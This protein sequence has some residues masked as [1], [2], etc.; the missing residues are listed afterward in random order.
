M[1]YLITC[2][3]IVISS[4]VFSQNSILDSPEVKNSTIEFNGGKYNGYLIEFNASPDIVEEAIKER[5]KLQGIKPKET[6]SFMV[7]RNVVIPL[8]DPVKPMDAF[9]KVERKSRKEKEQTIVYFISAN[10]G[11]IPED[12]LKS[13]AASKSVGVTGIKKGDAF[14]T[15]LIPDV[16]QGVYNKDLADQQSQLKK[17]EKKLS[18]LLDDQADMEKKLKKLQSDLEFN[19]KAQ[20]RQSAEVEKMKTA[21][22]E[23]VLKNPSKGGQ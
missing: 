4:I 5:F 11:E 13:D 3:L 20:E 23:L 15:G 16:K 19:K 22:N 8:I 2:L 18:G 10:P 1:R 17:E 9:I 14:L 12:K 6:K 21:L 7:Y